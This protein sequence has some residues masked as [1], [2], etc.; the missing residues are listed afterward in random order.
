MGGGE[1]RRDML[2]LSC[3]PEA[4]SLGRGPRGLPTPLWWKELW[5]SVGDRP[6]HLPM[7]TVGSF[8]SSGID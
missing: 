8:L 7:D 5:G 1:G 4:K 3:L 6:P 2:G